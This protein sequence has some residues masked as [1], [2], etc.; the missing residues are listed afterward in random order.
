M[1]TY[2][3]TFLSHCARDCDN[4]VLLIVKYETISNDGGL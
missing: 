2:D 1:E 4:D 3:K